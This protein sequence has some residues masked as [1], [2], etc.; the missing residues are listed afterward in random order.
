M[1]FPEIEKFDF[2]QISS[3]KKSFDKK[4]PFYRRRENYNYDSL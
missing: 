1:N 4:H 3:I 2:S